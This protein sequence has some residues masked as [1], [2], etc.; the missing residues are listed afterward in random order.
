MLLIDFWA[1]WCGPC[2]QEMP[3]VKRI[4]SKYN[5]KGFEIVGISLDRSRSD[6]DQ[7]IEKYGITWPQ[8]YDGKFWRNDV[9][10]KYNVQSIPATYLVDKKGNIRYKSLRGD[11]LEAA[12]KKLLEE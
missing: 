10:V 9:A 2:K 12:I 8:F 5:K 11:Q 3:N 6:L 7:Y 1:T 4:Y